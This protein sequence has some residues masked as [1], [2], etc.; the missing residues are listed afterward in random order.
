MALK[1]V[2]APAGCNCAECP[3]AGAGGIPQHDPVL[4][5]GP[6]RTHAEVLVVGE[7]P[8]RNE[9]LYG[10]PFVGDSGKLLDAIL[11]DAGLHRSEVYVT[12]SVLCAPKGAKP[13]ASALK[14][15]SGRLLGEIRSVGPKVVVT[16][17]THAAHSLLDTRDG[18]GKLDGAVY[19]S[20]KAGVWVVP[21]YHPAAILR[22]NDQWFDDLRDAFVRARRIVD[23]ELDPSAPHEVPWTHCQT[24]EEVW[25][26]LERLSAQLYGLSDKDE[27]VWAIDVESDSNRWMH[28][29]LLQIGIYDGRHAWCMEFGGWVWTDT[30]EKDRKGRPILER[31]E[32]KQSVWDISCV[33]MLRELL[34]DE[35][36]LWVAHNMSFDMQYL[37]KYFGVMPARCHDTMAMAMTQTEHGQRVGLKKLARRYFN[38]PD[39]ESGIG[40]WRPTHAKAP[41]DEGGSRNWMSSVP[42]PL[43]AN[44]LAYDV[45][46]TH[47]LYEQLLGDMS[48]D[49]DRL[50][51][52]LLCPMQRV[53]AEVQFHGVK[54]DLAMTQELREKW[55][56]HLEDLE[57]KM[58]DYAAGLGFRASRVVKALKDRRAKGKSIPAKKERLNVK[59]PKQLQHFV[60]DILELTPPDKTRTTDKTFIERWEHHA[61]VRWLKE[62]REVSKMIGTYVDG[63][64]GHVWGD[65]RAHP[66]VKLAGAR[67][68]RI[69]MEN[70]PIQTIP[71][72]KKGGNPLFAE[73]RKLFVPSEGHTFVDVDYKQLEVRVLYALTQDEALGEALMREDFHTA[74]AAR[75]HGVAYEEVTKQLRASSK[76]LVFAI[77]YGSGPQSIG[78]NLGVTTRE[79]SELIK[80]FFEL[81]PTLRDWYYE[82]QRQAIEEGY[83]ETMTGRRRR[84]PL[85]T[86]R[87]IGEIRRTSVN[88]AVQSLASDINLLAMMKIHNK[89]RRE[90]WGHVLFAVH[91]SIPCEIKNQHLHEAIAYMRDTME[92]PPLDLNA[93]FEVDV[94]VGPNWGELVTYEPPTAAGGSQ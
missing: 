11:D 4:G 9:I 17:G 88:M 94:E 21:T 22:G 66:A 60:Y 77:I 39:Y 58:Q 45:W 91:D 75:L 82:V 35:R 70:P 55:Q 13:T 12:N 76:T 38:A 14:A 74:A 44:Y 23:G 93:T 64:A 90:G 62:Y 59:S 27:V 89:L 46:Y 19:W 18:I 40:K 79:A 87:N 81:F 16:L 24:T 2:E 54:V 61:F 68:G 71:S 72:G 31:S 34:E 10:R 67:T 1:P 30:G 7:G 28:D 33:Q 25:G 69:S 83:V 8:G 42:R 92:N 49:D 52:G 20:G 78:E 57:R 36:I 5:R 32:A 15:C 37:Q 80:D 85:V 84:Y 43:M 53:F 41:V 51:F 56:P 3:L 48:P 6:N 47:R 26:A 50:A 86:R 65:G 63:I 73:A 29:D